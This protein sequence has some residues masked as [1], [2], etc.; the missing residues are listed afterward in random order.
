M[1]IVILRFQ[2][3][4]VNALGSNMGTISNANNETT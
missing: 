3:I 1:K 2:A 4:F